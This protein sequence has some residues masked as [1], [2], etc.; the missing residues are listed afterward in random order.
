MKLDGTNEWPAGVVN[1][2]DTYNV[3]P[4]VLDPHGYDPVVAK[5][6]TEFKPRFG[7]KTLI[8]VELFSLASLNH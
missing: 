7:F 6:V 3:P 4:Q 1:G 8:V 5:L 2:A